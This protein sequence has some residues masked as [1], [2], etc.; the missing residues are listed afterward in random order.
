MASRLYLAVSRLPLAVAMLVASGCQPKPPAGP[1]EGGADAVTSIVVSPATVTLDPG[2]S[3]KLTAE[4]R[5]ADGSVVATA[6]IV[7]STS[8]AAVATVTADGTVTAVAGG[9]AT[10]TASSGTVSQ[11]AGLTVRDVYDLDARGIPTLITSHYLDLASIDRISLFRSAIGHD[12]SDS[13]ERCRSMK[14]YF[15]PRVALD[16]STLQVSSPAEGTIVDLRPETTFGRR[17]RFGRRR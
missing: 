7:W 10:I 4:A 11:S 15:M 17:C 6:T 13:V 16:W 9:A 8:S 3:A 12:Y 1:S 5:R 14:H 2:R